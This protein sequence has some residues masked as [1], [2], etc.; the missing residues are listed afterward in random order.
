MSREIEPTEASVERKARRRLSA[1]LTER[2]HTSRTLG[3]MAGIGES[4][5][6]E[7]DNTPRIG[8]KTHFDLDEQTGQYPGVYSY[9]LV[10]RQRGGESYEVP[11]GADELSMHTPIG[12]A[13]AGKAEGDEVIYK[14]V[15]GQEVL[16][17]ILKIHSGK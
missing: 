2:S 13:V 6:P 16:A 17:R 14:T 11:D 1:E 8:H 12:E 3:R 7:V 15:R 4:L 10:D 5:S 9:F